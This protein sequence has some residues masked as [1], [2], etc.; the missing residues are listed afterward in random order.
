MFYIPEGFIPSEELI[1]GCETTIK[2]GAYKRG[3][4]FKPL[5]RWFIN[6]IGHHIDDDYII[7]I[8]RKLHYYSGP[9]HREIINPKA[10]E[11]LKKQVGVDNFNKLILPYLQTPKTYGVSHTDRPLSIPIM[12]CTICNYSIRRRIPAGESIAFE[13]YK[14]WLKNNEGL[15]IICYCMGMP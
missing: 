6:S 4:G 10:F 9:N 1:C 7:F 5:N 11:F 2:N 15:C 13:K 12:N 3:L 14:A 8:P